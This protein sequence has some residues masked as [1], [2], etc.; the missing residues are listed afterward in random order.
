MKES[1]KTLCTPI[2]M[3]IPNENH[4]INPA[5]TGASDNILPN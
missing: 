5:E 3:G 2:M 1:D 4:K